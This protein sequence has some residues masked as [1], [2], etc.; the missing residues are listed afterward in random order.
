MAHLLGAKELQF[1]VANPFIIYDYVY[2]T[3]VDICS[4]DHFQDLLVHYLLMIKLNTY[5]MR[6]YAIITISQKQ[7]ATK[8][9]AN[10]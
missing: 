3:E 10:Q 1:F 8:I 6:S 5:I 2:D 7:C 9:L 4:A